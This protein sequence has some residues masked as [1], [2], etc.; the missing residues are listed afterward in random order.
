MTISELMQEHHRRCDAAFVAAEESLRAGRWEIG[1][2]ALADFGRELE[3]HFAAEEEILFPAFEGAT[4]M[5]QG[6]TQM[7][8]YEHDQMRG[9]LAQLIYA[10]AAEDGDEVAGAGETLLVLMQQHNAK[11][12]NILYPMCDSAL[13]TDA[14]T[15]TPELRQRLTGG[16]ASP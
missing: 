4:G 7:M 9:L 10:A 15:L 1:R 13:E 14:D 2:A 8:R 3:S 12:E 16:G 11:E 5:R 6:P